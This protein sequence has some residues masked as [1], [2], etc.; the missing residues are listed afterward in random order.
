MDSPP[1]NPEADLARCVSEIRAVAPFLA[2]SPGMERWGHQLKFLIDNLKP[3][4]HVGDGNAAFTYNKERGTVSFDATSLR[5]VRQVVERY[6]DEIGVVWDLAARTRALEA[7]TNLFVVHEL[8]HIV[9]NFPHFH[10]VADVKRALGPDGLGLALLDTAADFHAAWA[11]ANIEWRIAGCPSD[12]PLEHFL[13]NMLFLAYVIG[14]RGFPAKNRNAK[15]QR[16][17]GVLLGATLSQASSVGLL[18][19]N[20]IHPGWK[21]TVPLMAFDLS[22]ARSLN[23]FM[24]E[25]ELGVLLSYSHAVPRNLVLAVWNGVGT[26][27]TKDLVGLLMRM[28]AISKVVRMP[29]EASQA[30]TAIEP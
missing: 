21:P 7:A 2:S 1:Y 12:V 18:D 6:I 29:A 19:R 28:L 13:T 5:A 17:L 10:I 4:V 25:P 3:A 23:A 8:T 24:T 22:E 15:T 30:R 27:P 20:A 14:A 16:F 9:Q 11:V 26:I